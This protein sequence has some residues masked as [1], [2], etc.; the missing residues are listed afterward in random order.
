MKKSLNILI[1]LVLLDLFGVGLLWYGYTTIQGMKQKETDIREQL[2]EE[3]QKWQKIANLKQTLAAATKDREQLERYLIDS[4]DENQIKLIAQ[5]EHLGASTGLLVTTNT[6]DLQT[7]K[8]PLLHGDFALTGTWTQLFHFMRLIEEF[9]SRVVIT[10]YDI[11][12]TP[13]TSL[14]KPTQDNWT[15]SMSIDFA[16][17]KQNPL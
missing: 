1:V 13:S 5:I 16:S 8:T 9:P 17:L 4:S 15:G 14:L 12:L 7:T 10:R 11:G 6:F 2:Q 3:G